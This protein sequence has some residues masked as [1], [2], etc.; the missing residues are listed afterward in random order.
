MVGVGGRRY[1]GYLLRLP[2]SQKNLTHKRAADNEV[3][4]LRLHL[5]SSE[6]GP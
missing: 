5:V 2:S 6:S 3:H 1:G 4:F